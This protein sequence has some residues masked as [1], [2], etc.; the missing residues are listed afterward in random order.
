VP[1]SRASGLSSSVTMEGTRKTA[2]RMK[3]NTIACY[4]AALR[5]DSR[6][7]LTGVLYVITVTQWR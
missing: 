4:A 1:A 3:A 5:E 7:G 6:L 2:N